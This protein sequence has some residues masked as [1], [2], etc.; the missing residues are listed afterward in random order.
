MFITVEGGEGVGKTTQIK[1]V[2]KWLEERGHD[3]VATREPGGTPLA[4][5]IRELVISVEQAD[6]P[7]LSELLL[8]FAARISHVEAV[9]APALAAGKTVLCD[10]FVDASYAYQGGGRGLPPEQIETLENWLPDIV[11][12]D[13]TILIDAPVEVGLERARRRGHSDRFERE[14]MDFFGRVRDAYLVRARQFPRRFIVIDAGHRPPKRV[15]ADILARLAERLEG[16]H[17]E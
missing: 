3:V 10:R 16:A 13:L 6:V 4:E 14:A 5:A 12:P 9:I 2:R 7:P 17:V 8:M 15:T 11:R 1:A